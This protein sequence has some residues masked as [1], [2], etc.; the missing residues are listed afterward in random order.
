[1][2]CGRGGAEQEV[3]AATSI[4]CTTL[5]GI[6]TTHRNVQRMLRWRHRRA[7]TS[8]ESCLT[9]DG[10]LIHWT[11]GNGRRERSKRCN[12]FSQ[13]AARTLRA[14]RVSS[15]SQ[16][17]ETR[18][19]ASRFRVLGAVCTAKNGA[20]SL[21]KPLIAQVTLCPIRLVIGSHVGGHPSIGPD[22]RFPLWRWTLR[23]DGFVRKSNH[24]WS[25]SELRMRTA[26][27]GERQVGRVN[28]RQLQVFR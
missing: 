16:T 10:P 11:G 17:P 27:G 26:K 15:A 2:R 19:T 24:L 6:S 14:R 23:D 22:R 12:Y 21:L 3:G 18:E 7:A 20:I 5:T 9:N 8:N 25:K 1:L 28:W 13:E 4:T